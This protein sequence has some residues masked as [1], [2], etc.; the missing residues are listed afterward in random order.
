MSELK[1]LPLA[2][3]VDL[4]SHTG[5]VG[6]NADH[7]IT[8]SVCASAMSGFAVLES[9][10]WGYVAEKWLAYH[11]E[12]SKKDGPVIIFALLSGGRCD[13]HVMLVSA[14]G[15]EIDGKLTWEQV[16]K[17]IERSGF[18]AVAWT[19]HNHLRTVQNVTWSK[20][21][22]WHL[23]IHGWAAA[24]TDATVAEFC[25]QDKRYS[26]LTNV[27]L[28]NGAKK[29]KAK[30]YNE[31]VE[32]FDIAHDV[33]HKIR[34]VF[35]LKTP[36]P[37]KTGV[38]D[39]ASYKALYHA[40]GLRTFGEAYSTES[41]NPSRIHYLPSHKPGCEHAVYHFAGQLLDPMALWD[42][43]KDKHSRHHA[44]KANKVFTAVGLDELEH[45]LKSIPPDLEYPDWFRCLAAIFHETGGNEQGNALAHE[46]SSGDGRYDFEQVERIW[47]SF[48][49]DRS[50]PATMGTLVKLAREHDPEFKPFRS[51]RQGLR[52]LDSM[53][54]RYSDE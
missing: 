30:A 4:T 38:F 27:R 26:H 48:N 18:E 8:V 45:V 37:L 5:L 34:I 33:E 31:W 7:P 15:F 35:P 29:Y 13:E 28:V 2:D 9:A 21:E 16:C 51:I 44:H 47:D 43:I 20:F 24:P 40:H 10:A 14:F 50:N 49:P 19:T 22:K 12:R 23:R 54:E 1:Q 17:C 52:L 39:I 25:A 46:W 6:A 32:V 42:G 3:G 11:D 53:I 41:A 36:I